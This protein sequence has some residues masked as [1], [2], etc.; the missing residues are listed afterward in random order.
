MKVRKVGCLAVPQDMSSR[1]KTISCKT[2][3]GK[4]TRDVTLFSSASYDI[5]SHLT[6]LYMLAASWALTCIETLCFHP[7]SL[8]SVVLRNC[9]SKENTP[10]SVPSRDE[11]SSPLMLGAVMFFILGRKC[12]SADLLLSVSFSDSQVPHSEVISSCNLAIYLK[13]WCSRTQLHPLH[14]FSSPPASSHREVSRFQSFPQL[15]V[16]AVLTP[17]E[18]CLRACH[19]R[20]VVSLPVCHTLELVSILLVLTELPLHGPR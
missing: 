8:L 9:W 17:L 18:S 13:S 4:W 19:S 3:E 6:L 20:E 12:A 15:R 1:K 5:I 14:P 11:G 10:L 16:W 2:R 7:Q